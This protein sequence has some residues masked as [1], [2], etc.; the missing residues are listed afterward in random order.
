MKEK[1]KF[2][3]LFFLSIAIFFEGSRWGLWLM[4][5]PNTIVFYL[6]LFLVLGCGFGLYLVSYQL[7]KQ[8]KN[9]K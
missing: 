8:I 1:L 4:N 3:F 9:K 5:M 6:G 2:I 7:V